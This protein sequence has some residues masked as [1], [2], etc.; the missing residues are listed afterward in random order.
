MNPVPIMKLVEIIPGLA[1][2]SA[3]L[4]TTLQLAHS[5]G[6]TTTQ[7]KDMPGTHRFSLFSIIVHFCGNSKPT[8]QKISP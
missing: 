5:M 2:D 7:S 3:T 1:T 4:N 6:K 8:Q